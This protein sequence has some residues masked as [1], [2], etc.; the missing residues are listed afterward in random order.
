MIIFDV[1]HVINGLHVVIK[2]ITKNI[3]DVFVKILDLL[4]GIVDIFGEF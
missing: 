1:L 2:T 4:L 3:N